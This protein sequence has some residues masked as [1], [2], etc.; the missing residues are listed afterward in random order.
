MTL[1]TPVS[2]KENVYAFHFRI[3]SDT[4][5]LAILSIISLRARGH[6]IADLV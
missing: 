1:I 6:Y 5:Q 4:I 3:S 2:L